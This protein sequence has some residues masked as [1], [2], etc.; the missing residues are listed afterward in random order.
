MTQNAAMRAARRAPS[1]PT[2][3]VVGSFADY[4]A[5]K[6]AVNR[7]SAQGFP[8]ERVAIIGSDLRS[9]ERVTG[10]MT[11][12]RAAISGLMTGV[13]L[14]FFAGCIAIIVN[15]VITFGSLLAMGLVAIGFGI[16]W[17]IAGFALSP[18]KRDFTSVMQTVA[19]RFDLIVPPE[20]AAA[21]RQALGGVAA[22]SPVAGAGASPDGRPG[23]P[24]G[25]PGSFDGRPGAGASAGMP[26]APSAPGSGQ[27]AGLPPQAPGAT[28]SGSGQSQPA[29]PVRPRTY[30]EAQ[31]ELRRREEAARR[32]GAGGAARRDADR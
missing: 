3:E 21:A 25:A 32:G 10:Q 23:S 13:M 24:F 26:E 17:S 29:A 1:V 4:A 5:A 22:A 8:I 31:D 9:V 28:A 15:P 14:A 20:Q 30:G 18:T 19:S 12:G 16:L 2:G 11:Y 27:G 7:L 6:D